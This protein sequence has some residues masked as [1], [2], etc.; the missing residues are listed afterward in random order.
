ME[1]LE[2]SKVR[3]EMIFIYNVN[4]VDTEFTENLMAIPEGATFVDRKD[5]L[6][7]EG[8]VPPIHDFTMVKEDSDYK[9]ECR[10][11]NC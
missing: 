4:G 8:Y 6:I 7:T 3:N 1:I 10:N 5:K 2:G 11:Q 9:E